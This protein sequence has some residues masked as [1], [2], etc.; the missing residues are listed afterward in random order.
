MATMRTRTPSQSGLDRDQVEGELAKSFGMAALE[1]MQWKGSESLL[2]L[3]PNC[4]PMVKI[5]LLPKSLFFSAS[6]HHTSH[7]AEQHSSQVTRR[8]LHTASAFGSG[9]WLM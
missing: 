9:L 2:Y 7:C 1:D 4:C 6:S 5:V 8:H 3:V